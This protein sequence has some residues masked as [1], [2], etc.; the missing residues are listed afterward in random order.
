MGAGGLGQP[1][2]TGLSLND[3]ELILEG[4]LPA[5]A[6]AIAVEFLFEIIEKRFVPAYLRHQR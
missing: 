5:A 1:I 2:I 3:N 4:A 6:L